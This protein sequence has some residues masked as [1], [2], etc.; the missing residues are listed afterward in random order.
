MQKGLK[1]LAAGNVLPSGDNLLSPDTSNQIN[2]LMT[3]FWS[4]MYMSVEDAQAK[5]AMIIASAD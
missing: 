1:I 3:T 5:Y 2:E 4:D